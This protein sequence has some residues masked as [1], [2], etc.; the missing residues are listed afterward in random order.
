MERTSPVLITTFYNTFLNVLGIL[1][2]IA[3]QFKESA[4]R[5]TILNF[6]F[7]ILKSL[8]A[9]S[10]RIDFDNP[11]Y[12]R[13]GLVRCRKSASLPISSINYFF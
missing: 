12:I 10:K 1:E 9:R 13:A 2:Q 7:V 11:F 5:G 8:L 4:R 6:G 3:A